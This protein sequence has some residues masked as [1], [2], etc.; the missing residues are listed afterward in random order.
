MF[1]D[2]PRR[3]RDAHERF[4]IDIRLAGG[5]QV[6]VGRTRRLWLG[7]AFDTLNGQTYLPQ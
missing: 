2:S 4:D 5:A 1:G 7:A 6:R 3:D